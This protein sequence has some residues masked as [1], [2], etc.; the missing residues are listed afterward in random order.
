MSIRR[1]LVLR[2]LLH[3]LKGLSLVRKTP[4]MTSYEDWTREQLIEKIRLLE[5]Q[6][7]TTSNVSGTHGT[8]KQEGKPFNFNA[9]AQRKIALKFCYH[10]WEYNGLAFQ[11]EPTPLPTIEGV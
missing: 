7:N 9:Y 2:R 8:K 3:T 6:Q 10:G 4:I 1:P 11:T 5:R